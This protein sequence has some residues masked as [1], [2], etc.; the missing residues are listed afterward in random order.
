[1][2][3]RSSP[4]IDVDGPQL[5]TADELGELLHVSGA[6]VRKRCRED[7][8]PHVLMPWKGGQ[9]YLFTP[10]QVALI[11]DSMLSH[12]VVAMRRPRTTTRTTTSSSRKRA[13]S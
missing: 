13:R 1:M 9:R 12:T 4:T 6:W 10:D 8:W 2:P 3:R 7:G 11:V 5:K